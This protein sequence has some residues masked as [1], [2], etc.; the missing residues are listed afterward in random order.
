MAR[1]CTVGALVPTATSTPSTRHSLSSVSAH[2]V[3]LVARAAGVVVS[4]LDGVEASYAT[5][6]TLHSK[7]GRTSVLKFQ[8]LQQEFSVYRQGGYLLFRRNHR[9][10]QF[11]ACFRCGGGS[12]R[13]K[14]SKAP[15]AC[16]L[17][18]FRSA[19]MER[20]QATSWRRNARAVSRGDASDAFSSVA[21]RSGVGSI[22]DSETSTDVLHRLKELLWELEFSEASRR[23]SSADEALAKGA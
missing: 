17:N 14:G 20:A 6:A 18:G 10:A 19:R 3:D 16:S 12:A 2:G 7:C 9:K 8:C 21:G 22:E 11:G 23:S 13:R 15:S 5:A 1:A 4:Q